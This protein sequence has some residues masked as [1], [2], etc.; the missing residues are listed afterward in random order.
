MDCCTRIPN[1]LDK[2][3]GERMARREAQ[4]Y[5]ERGLD[6]PARRLAEALRSRGLAGASV[7]EIGA[8][9]GGLHLDLLK[10]G[11]SSAVD[12]DL[13]PAYLQAARQTA[14]TLGFAGR[15]EHRLHN[16]ADEPQAVAPADVVVMNRVICCYPDLERLLG[17]AA[18]RARRLLALTFPRSAWWSRL[19]LRLLNAGSWLIRSEFRTYLHPPSAV[20]ALAAGAGLAPVHESYSGL[21]QVVVFERAAG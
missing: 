8:G 4:G 14:Q 5:L 20:Y 3:F 2:I 6:Q 11:A 15:V 17:P 16:I 12:L 9:A 18:A 21:W 10:A 19:G 1:G 7:L 13:S